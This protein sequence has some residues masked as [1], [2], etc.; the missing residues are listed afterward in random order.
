MEDTKERLILGQKARN[1]I[2]RFDDH[3]K[4]I[5]VTVHDNTKQMMYICLMNTGVE[6]MYLKLCIPLFCSF[7][8]AYCQL[9]YRYI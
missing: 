8:D 2:K 5:D 3:V 7:F 9:I 6:S 1:Y 4:D